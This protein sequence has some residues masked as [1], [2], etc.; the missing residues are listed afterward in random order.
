MA[1]TPAVQNT[2][3]LLLQVIGNYASFHIMPHLHMSTLIHIHSPT[4]PSH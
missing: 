1:A 4:I 3:R 2:Q